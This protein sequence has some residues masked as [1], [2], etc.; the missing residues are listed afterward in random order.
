MFDLCT[1]ISSLLEAYYWE[2]KCLKFD[3]LST[4]SLSVRGFLAEIGPLFSSGIDDRLTPFFFFKLCRWFV[5]PPRL[6]YYF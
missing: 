6:V 3:G 2:S 5:N 1:P 4:R